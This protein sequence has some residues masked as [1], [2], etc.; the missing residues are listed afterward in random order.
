MSDK[1]RSFPL[2]L[3]ALAYLCI[4]LYT[5]EDAVFDRT[6]G[7]IFVPV[8]V[9]QGSLAA[10]SRTLGK[11]RLIP[12]PAIDRLLGGHVTAEQLEHDRRT[13]ADATGWQARG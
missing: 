3:D 1:P 8:D 12:V 9:R 5:V 4:H 13:L 2:S 10:L 11:A 7:H 6:A